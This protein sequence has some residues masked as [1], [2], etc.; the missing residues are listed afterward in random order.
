MRDVTVHA[1]F[2][3]VGGPPGGGYGIIVRDTG[4]NRRDGV[5]QEGRYYVFEAGDRGEYGV[6]RREGG[7]W[8]ELVPWTRTNI[9]LPGSASNELTVTARGDRLRFLIN[10]SEVANL[11]DPILRQGGV[12]MFAG[13]D[14]NEVVVE[15]YTVERD[16]EN[17][18]NPGAT[19][20][21]PVTSGPFL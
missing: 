21:Q 20:L 9:V 4:V 3:K 13:G 12:G 14:G 18:G 1:R 16:E 15:R 10:G 19:T 11:T 7:S 17:A 8:V 2:R 6:W 5:S